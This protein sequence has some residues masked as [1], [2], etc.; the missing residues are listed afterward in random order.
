MNNTVSAGRPGR[1]P[2]PPPAGAPR[3]PAARLVAIHVGRPAPIQSGGMHAVSAIDKRQVLGPVMVRRLNIDGDEQA[4]LRVHGGP[5]KAVYCCPSEHYAAWSAELARA[6]PFGSFGENLTVAGLL[7][8]R[9]RI[10]DVLLVGGAML[11]VTQPRLPCF[12]LGIKFGDPRFVRQFLRSGRP[13]FYCRVLRE[14]LIEAGQ[15]IEVVERTES[16]LTVAESFA[17]ALP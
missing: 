14:G 7:E 8:D 17:A 16:H 1:S 5:D 10:G 2:A 3:M 12:K 6:V 15:R 11:Q 13:G 9:L 4:D